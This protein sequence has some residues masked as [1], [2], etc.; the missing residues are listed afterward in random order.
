MFN[1]PA[2]ILYQKAFINTGKS[3]KGFPAAGSSCAKP[4]VG[5]GVHKPAVLIFDIDTLLPLH[6]NTV[7]MYTD[8]TTWK[9][10]RYE[11]LVN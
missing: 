6:Y 5:I 2:F 7:S 1:V 10:K 9:E 4:A 3:T 11:A 8:L